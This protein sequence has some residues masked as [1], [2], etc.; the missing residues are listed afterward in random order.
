M[1]RL[2]LSFTIVMWIATSIMAQS[3]L[4][5]LRNW[6]GKFPVST[7]GEPH[8]NIYQTQPLQRRLVK[9]LGWKNYRC[10]LNDY[11]VMGRIEL[12][13]DY[14]IV[15]HCERGNCDESSSFMAV[16]FRR[17][18]LHV[19]FYKLGTLQW[20]HSKGRARD[21]PRSIF[22]TEWW[23]SNAPF[24]KSITETTETP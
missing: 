17:G 18:D 21:L 15:D 10:L 1:K 8:R 4:G 22:E 20:F 19:A 5:Y 9:L 3:K 12:A 23:Q 7:P 11:Y 14:V 2:A 24:V 6:V 16:N 13:G